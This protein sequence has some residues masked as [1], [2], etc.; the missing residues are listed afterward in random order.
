[1][2][3]LLLIFRQGQRN[4]ARLHAGDDKKLYLKTG[5]RKLR[6]QVVNI[7]DFAIYAIPVVTT[8]LCC[9]NVKVG[10]DSTKINVSV[11]QYNFVY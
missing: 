5:D 6:E 2:L 4:K 11:F 1:M 10:I 7:L 8:Q 3:V 9:C